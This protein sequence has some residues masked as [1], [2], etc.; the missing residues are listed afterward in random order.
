MALVLAA[1][2]SFLLGCLGFARWGARELPADE[3]LTTLDIIYRSFQLFTLESGAVDGT[4][5]LSLEA[6]RFLAPAVALYAAI[7]ATFKIFSQRLTALSVRRLKQHVIVC[8]LGESG[9]L[10]AENLRTAGIPMVAVEQDPDVA[11]RSR[12][13]T[14]EALVLFGDATDPDVLVRAGIARAQYVIAVCGDDGINADIAASCRRI[15]RR[16]DVGIRCLVHIHDLAFCELLERGEVPE[17]KARGFSIDFFNRYE[18]G[19]ADVLNRFAPFDENGMRSAGILL[20]GTTDMSESLVVNI[21]KRWQ[22]VQVEAGSDEGKSGHR[23]ASSIR[24]TVVGPDATSYCERLNAAYADLSQLCVLIPVD[25]PD[26]TVVSVRSAVLEMAAEAPDV[27]YVSASDDA[28]TVRLGLAC[29]SALTQPDSEVVACLTENSG[30]ASLLLEGQDLTE[31]VPGLRAHFVTEGLREPELLFGGTRELLARAIHE[32]YLDAEVRRGQTLGASP[33]LVNWDEL[34]E[35]Y[36]AAN[37]DQA[38]SIPTAL[39]SVGL[40]A[41]PLL[42]WT[43]E[44]FEFTHS[45]LELLGTAE[46]ERWLQQKIEQGWKYA[47]IEEPDRERKLS[48]CIAPWSNLSDRWR[49]KDFQAVLEWPRILV[50]IGYRIERRG[51]A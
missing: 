51:V 19:A 36:R 41:V 13:A 28:E 4:V 11:A 44:P 37:R 45:E 6:A 47:E 3:A 50:T 22:I 32:A 10:I 43:A 42:N 5:P 20:V 24:V 8:G 14:H 26:L 23:T 2:G 16:S 35:G 18:N 15:S 12:A 31:P 34:A 30:V 39:S 7:K 27:A 9:G 38:R 48:P 29:R 40:E 33:V 49:E 17:D 25:V 46:H 21:A 1:A